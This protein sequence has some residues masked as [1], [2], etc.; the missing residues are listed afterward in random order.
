MIILNP[1]PEQQK[2]LLALTLRFNNL[3]LSVKFQ[4][5][6]VGPIVTTYFY[7][8]D[9]KT[10][11]SNVMARNDDI[12]LAVGEKVYISR[13]GPYLGVAIPNKVKKIV[14]FKDYLYWYM[15]NEAVSLMRIPFPLGQSIQGDK[16]ALDLAD[17][18]HILISGSTNSGKSILESAIISCFAYRFSSN[19]LK[20]YL[21]DTKKVDLS[22]FKV[23]SH[24]IET[25]EDVTNFHRIAS[26]ILVEIRNRLEKLQG[27]S[28]RNIGDFHKLGLKMP[29]IILMIDE[30]ADLIDQDKDARLSGLF[31]DVPNINGW[32]KS[33][34]QI[35][36]AAGI[37]IIACTQRSSVKV[38]GGDTKVNFPCRIALRLPTQMDSRVILDSGG[39]EN[40]LGNGDMLIK[41]PGIDD[42]LRC[43]GPFVSMTDIENLV[44]NYEYIKDSFGA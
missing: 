7:T 42:L 10:T 31:E 30:L 28:C 6:E 26:V 2:A 23:L 22:L 38:V 8:L 1:E 41:C 5:L 44:Y 33:I 9:G 12:S 21:V 25:V 19:D 37:H 18:P 20:L 40:L 13:I 27:A 14:D 32:M 35:S 17:M 3:N 29:Y 34:A 39:A 11:V 36:R 16:I 43:H 15:K 24:V 4:G